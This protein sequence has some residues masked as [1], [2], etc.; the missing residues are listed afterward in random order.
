MKVAKSNNGSSLLISEDS[1]MDT[2]TTRKKAVLIAS[3]FFIITIVGAFFDPT[4]ND[5]AIEQS[6][7]RFK[8]QLFGDL[9]SWLTFGLGLICLTLNV[10]FYW[11]AWFGKASAIR[12][13]WALYISIILFAIVDWTA[14]ASLGI[15]DTLGALSSVADGVVF[16][17]LL[18]ERRRDSA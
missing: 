2:A 14:Q 3:I 4:G 13:F 5:P 15:L 12:Y 18:I 17:L 10:L 9:T 16:A 11:S 8:L 7:D 6:L 1:Q